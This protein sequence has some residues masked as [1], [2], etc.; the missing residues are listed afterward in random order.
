MK[1]EHLD[2]LRTP[3]RPAAHPS[4]DYAVLAV[5]RPDLEA[6]A[7]RS[8]LWRIDLTGAAGAPPVALTAGPR[9]SEP[10]ISPDG[11]WI[12][13]LRA[14]EAGP[15]Q[16]AVLDVRGGEPVVLTEHVLGVAG[17]AAWSPD[18]ARLAYTARVPEEGRYGSVEGV[19]PDAEPARHITTYTYRHDGLGFGVGRPAQ[20][21]VVD[22]PLPA[23]PAAAPAQLAP[24]LRLT[25]GDS[26]HSDPVWEPGGAALVVRRG[27]DDALLVDLVRL[28]LPEAGEVDVP[29]TS[30]DGDDAAHAPASDDADRRR[31]G[32]PVPVRGQ[33]VDLTALVSLTREGDPAGLTVDALAFAGAGEPEPREP[34]AGEPGADLAEGGDAVYLLVRDL[35]PDGLDFVGRN[36]ALVRAEL[37]G[38]ESGA[39]ALTDPQRLTDP[40]VDDLLGG[41]GTGAFEVAADGSALLRRTRRGRTELVRVG[42]DGVVVVHPGSVTGAATLPDGRV[43]ASAT[44][45][46]SPGETLLIDAATLDAAGEDGIIRL[47]DLAAPLRAAVGGAF[48]LPTPV[49]GA[50]APDGVPVHG[51][52][53]TPDAEVH[54]EGPYP[55]LLLIH[56]GPY[57]AYEDVFFDEV[58]VAAGAGYAVVY[59]NLRG[60]AG[61]GS[62]HGRAILEGFGTVDT[63]DVLALLDRALAT[64][65][66]LDASRVGVMG[67]SYGGYLTA[68]L[69]TRDDAEERFRGAIVER[70]FLD[71]V[72]F[73]GSSDIGWFFGLR[74]LGDDAP[75]VAAQSPMAHIARVHTPT[76]VIH[77]EQDWRCPVEQG[78]RWYVG[79]R[80][81]GVP[82]EL[83]LFPGEGHE[84]TRSG[85]PKHR[86][87]RFEA[88]LDWW[89]RYLPH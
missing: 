83:L 45:P 8:R 19:G 25:A 52:V 67:G 49:E 66:E 10:V 69:T 4:G 43:I 76:L 33:V 85:R 22:V 72:S 87:Q 29:D 30:D 36:P 56:G 65:P 31:R 53:V 89:E 54:G 75:K 38:T 58:A 42:G 81:R 16:L 11:R 37:T 40:E 70:G 28:P 18:S 21:F 84:L 80:R 6:D 2:L 24:P 60:S 51:W 34:R 44:L 12:A 15:P 73:E 41:V 63:D 62:A 17:R 82:S 20:V 64:H 48:R 77:S 3:G 79:L 14:P 86:R 46:D 50:T 71:P 27:R 9:D 35:G 47:T 7:Y 26:S 55:T 32:V 57:A 59:G 23:V 1:P 39:P 13:F 74:Y 61:Y 78:Q 68:W 5:S 88:V